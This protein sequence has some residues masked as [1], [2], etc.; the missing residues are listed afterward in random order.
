MLPP[1]GLT[2]EEELLTET[3]MVASVSEMNESSSSYIDDEDDSSSSSSSLIPITIR[4]V[5]DIR[6]YCHFDLPDA[7][8]KITYDES[9]RLF[10]E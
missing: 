2:S 8:F 5:Y 10:N 3:A 1:S 7:E 9:K 6:G 4:N